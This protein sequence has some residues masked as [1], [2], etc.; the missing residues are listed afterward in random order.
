MNTNELVDKTVRFLSTT[1]GRD[2]V[3]RFVQYFARFLAW[4]LQKNG[5]DKEVLARVA[6]LAAAT[7]IT[8]KVMRTGR[9]LEFARGIVKALAIKDDVIRITTI[10]K[11]VFMAAW[12]SFDT[13]QWIHSAGVY[14]FENIKEIGSRAFKCWLVALLFSFAGD[15]YKLQLNAKKISIES[16]IAKSEKA[17]ADEAVIA[18]R[19]I[20]ALIAERSKLF[21]TAVQDGV[22]I[23][24]PSAGLEYLSF[25][26][27]I[28]GL[29]GAFTSLLGGYAHWNSL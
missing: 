17:P 5:S 21:I 18:R 2:R 6:G 24:L 3:N 12:L 26:S 27:G 28:V 14:K 20:K 8:R 15:I 25:D 4:H 9:Q 29:A 22:D 10:F 11:S 13:C 1:V 16:K 7:A 23:I 19:N